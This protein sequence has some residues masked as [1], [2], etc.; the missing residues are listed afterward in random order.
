MRMIVP[1][2]RGGGGGDAGRSGSGAA[3]SPPLALF[4]KTFRTRLRENRIAASHLSSAGRT[5]R[6]GRVAWVIT[7]VPVPIATPASSTPARAGG[8][9]HPSPVAGE[10]QPSEVPVP[11]ETRPDQCLNTRLNFSAAFFIFDLR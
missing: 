2:H 3:Y 6:F 10:Q 11:A 5:D 9:A 4:L 7:P 1:R 8:I